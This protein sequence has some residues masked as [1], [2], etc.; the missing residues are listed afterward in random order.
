MELNKTRPDI[1][2]AKHS[3]NMSDEERFQNEILRPIIKMQHDLLIANY[4]QILVQ[5]KTPFHNITTEER[6]VIIDNSLKRDVQ[7]KNYLKGM[8]IGCMTIDEYNQYLTMAS[9][10]NRRINN[11]IKQ[12]LI[13]SHLELI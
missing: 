5:R 7:L 9:S 4:R 3:V 6:N 1:P 12:R 10:L 13:D 2:M 8:I 11:I